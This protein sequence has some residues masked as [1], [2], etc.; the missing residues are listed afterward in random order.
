[1]TIFRKLSN[2]IEITILINIKK[3]QFIQANGALNQGYAMAQQK[4]YA[5]VLRDKHLKYNKL[6]LLVIIDVK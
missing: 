6:N 2:L 1:L 3:L 4:Q 5:S